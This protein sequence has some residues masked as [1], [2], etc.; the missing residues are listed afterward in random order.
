M[1][2]HR[3]FVGLISLGTLN[4]C[5]GTA[6]VS[7]RATAT[8]QQI[9][10]RPRRRD[11]QRVL[12]DATRRAAECLP[13]AAGSVTVTGAFL[14]ATGEFRVAQIEPA[15]PI[16]SSVRTCVREEFENARVDPF[17]DEHYE[18]SRTFT[19][20]GAVVSS[21]NGGASGGASEAPA[22]TATATSVTP[23]TTTTNGTAAS[24][25]PTAGSVT[26]VGTNATTTANTT[27]VAT[28][29][30]N[31][32]TV[33][34]SNTGTP[35]TATATPANN[36]TAAVATNSGASTSVSSTATGIRLPGA[37]ADAGPLPS[38]A[39]SNCY[40]T[41]VRTNPSVGGRLHVQFE[42]TP[43]GTARNVSASPLGAMT[44]PATLGASAARC[45]EQRVRA[46]AFPRTASGRADLVVTLTPGARGGNVSIARRAAGILA[47]A[48]GMEPALAA[49]TEPTAETRTFEQQV[50][51]TMRARLNDVRGCYSAQ[52][53][54]SH[55]LALRTRVRF[56]IDA[57][58][59]VSTASST[60]MLLGGDPEAG[61]TV[62]QCVEG[63]V[64]TTAFPARAGGAPLETSLPFTF[65]G[66]NTAP[67]PVVSAPQAT[68]RIDPTATSAAIRQHTDEVRA[69]YTRALRGSPQLAGR[70]LVSF[71]VD[72]SGHVS[73]TRSQV[74]PVGGDRDSFTPV[75]LC[76][77]Q[78]LQTVTLPPPIGG[79]AAV[80]LPFDFSPS[81]P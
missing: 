37:S 9:R 46:Y 69:C 18:S 57:A 67:A 5:S 13:P 55:D 52:L 70:V 47:T 7:A 60:T 4:G 23:S 44:G 72:A 2:L 14:G 20:D 41:I 65:S 58:G 15:A 8:T 48:P 63:V 79:A 12:G 30:P 34:P 3:L 29:T 25:I 40:A 56:T 1:K 81:N 50:G 28:A 22:A 16:G 17:A 74:T 24:A 35:T 75:A 11:V 38:S 6:T 26:T 49:T 53:A 59:A 21:T 27:A 45:I 78:L 77:E 62:A 51:D 54:R 32:T 39:I 61:T 64:R 36:G 73:G 80:A 66:T 33:T 31:T 76:I 43:D 71:T 68:G 19:P 42:I 10:R